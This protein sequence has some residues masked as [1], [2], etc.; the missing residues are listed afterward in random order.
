MASLCITDVDDTDGSG[1]GVVAFHCITQMM[2][3]F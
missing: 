2:A 1:F 3:A